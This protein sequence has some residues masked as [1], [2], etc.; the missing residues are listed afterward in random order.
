MCISFIY[1]QL[2]NTTNTDTYRLR[3]TQLCSLKA[4]LVP[5]HKTIESIH[6]GLYRFP[7]HFTIQRP[8]LAI[9]RDLQMTR[10]ISIFQWKPV[11]PTG[12]AKPLGWEPFTLL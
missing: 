6:F 3:N 7:D 4:K 5:L 2:L 11:G 8:G 12:G 10:L 9:V 1:Y